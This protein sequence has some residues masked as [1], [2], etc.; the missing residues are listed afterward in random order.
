MDALSENV[1][2][3]GKQLARTPPRLPASMMKLARSIEEGDENEDGD[4]E[5][6]EAQT[7]PLMLQL[8][9]AAA[10][11]QQQ[12]TPTQQQQR[13]GNFESGNDDD[14]SFTASLI[15]PAHHAQAKNTA[16]NGNGNGNGKRASSAR[17]SLAAANAAASSFDGL[18]EADEFSIPVSKS[19]VARTP[20]Y[21]IFS[22][23][24]LCCN[25][26]ESLQ[27]SLRTTCPSTLQLLYFVL[28]SPHPSISLHPF[29]NHQPSVAC[30][31]TS[32]RS[33]SSS[34]RTPRRRA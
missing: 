31:T 30:R 22:R 3:S 24:M 12:K 11:K 8:A 19:R 1:I 33:P 20:M 9:N 29:T 28:S 6:D 27:F 17:Q 16:N 7:Q 5:D 2:S 25:F 13:H 34:S 32:C 21:G 14:L 26:F 23:T 18:D 15:S 4:G 10:S